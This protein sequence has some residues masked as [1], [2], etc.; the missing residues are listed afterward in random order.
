MWWKATPKVRIWII[1]CTL[2]S[3]CRDKIFKMA[4]IQNFEVWFEKNTPQ[5]KVHN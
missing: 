3:I 4:I 2:L 5:N 1:T